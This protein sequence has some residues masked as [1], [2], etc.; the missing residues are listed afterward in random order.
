MKAVIALLCLVA[1]ASAA[2]TP[3]QREEVLDDL[4]HEI[5]PFLSVDWN[6]VKNAGISSSMCILKNLISCG[7]AIK[8]PLIA[9]CLVASCGGDAAKLAYCIKL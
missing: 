6:C 2:Y 5:V 3:A 1:V 9:V 8:P 4:V 7:V